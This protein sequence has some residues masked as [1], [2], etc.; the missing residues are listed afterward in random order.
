MIVGGVIVC[1][2]V[3]T[4]SVAAGGRS[5]AAYSSSGGRLNWALAG[6]LVLGL[7][8]IGPPAGDLLPW[9]TSA[10]TRVLMTGLAMPT[11]WRGNGYADARVGGCRGAGVALLRVR[12]S[13]LAPVRCGAAGRRSM[14]RDRGTR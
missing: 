4:A 9:A 8:A 10:Q 5:F 6:N 3:R 12:R 11:H 7:M 14:A 1:C 2:S 13:A